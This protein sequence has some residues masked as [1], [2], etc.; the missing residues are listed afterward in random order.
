MSE[1]LDEY[2]IVRDVSVDLTK[3]WTKG[4]QGTES[5]SYEGYKPLAI[6][7]WSLPYITLVTSSAS[8]VGE[9]ND[10]AVCNVA[11]VGDG[12]PYDE[13]YITLHVMY[14]KDE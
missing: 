6:V 5:L 4:Y 2:L 10:E 12:T 8:I 9:S 11:Y 1:M 7:G 3:V 14:V 13:T